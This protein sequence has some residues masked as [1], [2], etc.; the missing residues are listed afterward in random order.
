[1]IGYL[2]NLYEEIT[3]MPAP[4]RRMGSVTMMIDAIEHDIARAIVSQEAGHSR[5]SISNAYIGSERAVKKG[6]PE[7]A[8]RLR[9]LTAKR[10]LSKAEQSELSDLVEILLSHH[11]AEKAT[12]SCKE[13]GI[14]DDRQAEL[15]I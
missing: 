8:D 1:M 11:D 10:Q 7:I 15:G 14:R 3:G 5:L 13:S 12:N 2:N 6:R 9:A 4:V